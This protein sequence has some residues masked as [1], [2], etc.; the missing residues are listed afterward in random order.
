MDWVGVARVVLVS[1]DTCD[2]NT[3]PSGRYDMRSGWT[4]RVE[5]RTRSIGRAEQTDHS[6]CFS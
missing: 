5:S 1:T 2:W 4:S 3:R 6:E